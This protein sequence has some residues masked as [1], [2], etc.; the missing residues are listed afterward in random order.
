MIIFKLLKYQGLWKWNLFVWIDWVEICIST[1]YYYYQLSAAPSRL[2]PTQLQTFLLH[3]NLW[4]PPSL[5]PPRK[6]SSPVWGRPAFHLALDGWP[7]WTIISNLSSFIRRKCPSHLNFSLIVA[8]ESM[9]EPC[10]SYSLFFE[11][12]PVSM[13]KTMRRKFLLTNKRERRK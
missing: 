1:S 13:P 2:R 7:T 3:P 5:H 11:V 6:P 8:L 12:R 4:K 9:I 10:F